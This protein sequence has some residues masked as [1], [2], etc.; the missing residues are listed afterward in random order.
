MMLQPTEPP[1]QGYIIGIL[2]GIVLNLYIALGSMNILVM[3]ILP[4]Y[5]YGICFHLIC[6]FFDFFLQCV[7]IFQIQVFYILG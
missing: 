7:I 3:L 6:I 4:I 5:E 1:S 2:I